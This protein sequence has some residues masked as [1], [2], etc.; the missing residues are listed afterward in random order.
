MNL[1]TKGN[2]FDGS[3][4]CGLIAEHMHFYNKAKIIG[5]G[6]EIAPSMQPHC[7]ELA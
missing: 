6:D 2:H 3:L 1:L 7:C 5:Y 4:D